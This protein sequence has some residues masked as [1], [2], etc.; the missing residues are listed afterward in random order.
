LTQV[1][2]SSVDL[3]RVTTLLLTAPDSA[4]LSNAARRSLGHSPRRDLRLVGT[5]RSSDDRRAD[6]A[7]W[8]AGTLYLG[9]RDCLDASPDQ[10]RI[11]ALSAGEFRGSW[12]NDQTG[13]GRR[14][15]STGKALPDP[16][17]YFCAEFLGET[18]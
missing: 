14:F 4:A 5:W 7:E 1:T 16:A 9:C 6:S 12:V 18:R 13:I 3:P 2:T 15:D 17:G 11:E 8:D 10:L